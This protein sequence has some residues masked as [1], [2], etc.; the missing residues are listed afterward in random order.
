MD[1]TKPMHC[2][3]TEQH[4]VL[5]AVVHYIF[6]RSCWTTGDYVVLQD[7]FIAPEL[8]G[9]GVGRALIEHI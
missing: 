5:V 3:V 4:G 8:R 2:A 7:L 6:H 1:P 9:K